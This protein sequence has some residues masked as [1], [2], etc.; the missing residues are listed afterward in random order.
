MKAQRVD[1]PGLA[2][3]ISIGVALLLTLA[4]AALLYLV[5]RR[6]IEDTRTITR[7][8]LPDQYVQHA[9][10]AELFAEIGLDMDGLCRAVRKALAKG[11]PEGELT[12]VG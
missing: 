12:A 7:L 2:F 5:A 1:N 9:E 10:R 6:Q 8:G 3:W 4:L 11:E